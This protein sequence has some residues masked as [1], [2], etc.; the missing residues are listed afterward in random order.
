MRVRARRTWMLMLTAAVCLGGCPGEDTSDVGT[1]T[2]DAGPPPDPYH[3]VVTPDPGLDAQTVIRR[4]P[5]LQAPAPTQVTVSWH[6]NGP[7][8]SRVALVQP[9]GS[10][11]TVEGT[12]FQQLP[13]TEDS[14]AAGVLPEGY[15][16]E[17]V[18]RGLL[19]NTVYT[20]R[21]LS[22][23]TPLTAQF[24]TAPLAG[25]NF[26]FLVMGDTRTNSA[27]HQQVVDA[28]AR[29]VDM[30]PG[31]MVP[32]FVV[33]TGDLVAAGGSEDNWD[34]FFGIERTL[35]SRVPLLAVF[36]NHEVILGR[37]IFEGLFTPPPS[38]TSPSERWYS[39]TLGDVHLAT[40]DV[41]ALNLE[42]HLQWLQEDMSASTAPFKLVFLH[43]PLFTMSLH[44]PE[45]ALRADLLP[46]LRAAGVQAIISGHNHCYERYD[47]DGLQ[48][49]VTGGS[50]APLYG[51]D[52]HPTADNG[53]AQRVV[54]QS[55][56][57]FMDARVDGQSLTFE[58]YSVPDGSRVDCFVLT[59]QTVG[60]TPCP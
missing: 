49:V 10:E 6:T 18:L 60:A 38:N 42:P 51:V 27:E 17:V 47:A 40:I 57:H 14:V 35:I 41:Y 45:V 53:T 55:T 26:R 2:A 16:H 54:A 34:T 39:A 52:E 13:T 12:T 43:P 58:V 19:P 46:V 25:D 32:R 59:A 56:F 48:S 44:E 31:G 5:Y 7:S 28:M 21:V 15:Q 23:A 9:D 30:A 29:V 22:A 1:G 36:G 24:T 33:N 3:D 37:T 11:R 4:G 50:G 8:T 20:Y